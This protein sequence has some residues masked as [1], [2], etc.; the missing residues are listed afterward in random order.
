MSLS[1]L[2][3]NTGITFTDLKYPS[4]SI[5]PGFVFCASFGLAL[6]DVWAFARASIDTYRSYNLDAASANL[7]ERFRTASS[8]IRGC[9]LDFTLKMSILAHVHF[10]Y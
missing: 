1:V 4:V 10:S 8:A 5:Q 2:I 7:T 6:H 3:R 9:G